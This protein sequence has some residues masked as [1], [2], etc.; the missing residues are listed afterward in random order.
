M[1]LFHDGG[2]DRSRTVAALGAVIDTLKARGYHFTTLSDAVGLPPQSAPAS[3]FDRWYGTALIAVIRTAA[4]TPPVIGWLLTGVALLT[5][6]R[7]LLLAV[8]AAV[9]Q[10][11]SAKRTP[12]AQEPQLRA[13][14]VVPAHNEQETIAACIR[15]LLAGGCPD[16]DIVVVD[17]GS[18]DAQTTANVTGLAVLL[19][20]RPPRLWD[21]VRRRPELIDGVIEETLRYA[22]VLQFGLLRV[23]REALAIAGQPIAPGD[24][25][26]LHLPAANRDPDRFA[27]PDTFDPGRP[28]AAKHLSFGHGPHYCLGDRLAR[29]E[30]RTLLT[31]MLRRFPDLRLVG[32]PDQ[33][34]THRHRVVHGPAELLVD[35]TP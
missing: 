7:L 27:D 5:A 4:V 6:A 25:I 29:I 15:A 13:S 2:G 16:I 34:P 35:F 12:S 30:L 26:V 19:L 20:L 32:A 22:T 1:I 31:T 9:H 33:T 14:A 11:R 23:A 24:R 18:T 8:A 3:T 21:T 10:R 28:D 17:D